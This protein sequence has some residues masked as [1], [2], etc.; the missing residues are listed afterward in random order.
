MK[1]ELVSHRVT[2]PTTPEIQQLFR[3]EPSSLVMPELNS[4]VRSVESSVTVSFQVSPIELLVLSQVPQGMGQE[5][6]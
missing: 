3:V 5:R 2:I 4:V 6:V 1:W